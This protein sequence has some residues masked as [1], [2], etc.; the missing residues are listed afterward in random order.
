MFPPFEVSPPQ[1]DRCFLL[2]C[3]WK[4][5]PLRWQVG[6]WL[7]K[8]TFCSSPVTLGQPSPASPWSKVLQGTFSSPK[9]TFA[10]RLPP[11]LLKAGE[12]SPRAPQPLLQAT[13][14]GW[15]AHRP[16]LKTSSA[17]R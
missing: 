10:P 16:G 13:A 15:A 17:P 8:A 14:G 6:F 4:I 11:V 12:Q 2:S 5:N 9:P 1:A 7:F 3:R